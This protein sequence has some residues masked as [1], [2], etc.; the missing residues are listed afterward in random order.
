MKT[1]AK[2]I[3]RWI[4]I[5]ATG[6]FGVWLLVA[7]GR[8]GFTMR[9]RGSGFDC[10]LRFCLLVLPILVATQFLVTRPPITRFTK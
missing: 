6:G 9:W 4:V 1:L 2:E 3:L 10:L 5:V 7:A 8:R